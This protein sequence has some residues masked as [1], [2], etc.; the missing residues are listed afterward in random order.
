MVYGKRPAGLVKRA[1]I[2]PVK[3]RVEQ[4]GGPGEEIE[5][6]LPQGGETKGAVLESTVWISQA[7]AHDACLF[8]VAQNDCHVRQGVALHLGV[9]VEEENVV[10]SVT[11]GGPKTQLTECR[12][13]ASGESQ[14]LLQSQ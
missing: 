8:Y 12:I 13:V 7:D 1:R 2:A 14:V 3:P 4:T 11:G 9:G 6:N 10:R 5:P